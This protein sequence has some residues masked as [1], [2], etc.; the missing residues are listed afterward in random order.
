M[1]HIREDQSAVEIDYKGGLSQVPVSNS[2]PAAPQIPATGLIITIKALK[3]ATA[4]SFLLNI[5]R[6]CSLV[7]SHLPYNKAK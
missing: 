6:L 3:K 1:K 2:G 7:S 4:E 5:F